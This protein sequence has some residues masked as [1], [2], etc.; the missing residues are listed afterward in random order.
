MSTE[1]NWI[2]NEKGNYV[3]REDWGAAKATV[4]R[5]SCGE[6]WGIIINSEEG[7]QYVTDYFEL[8]DDAMGRAEAFLRGVSYEYKLA[9]PKVSGISQWKQQ[10]TTVN[11]VPSY[12][13]KIGNL[14]V[15]VKRAATG[16]WFYMTYS[17]MTCSAPA[18]WYDSAEKAMQVF[19]SRH[20]LD[21][22]TQ[23]ALQN[24]FKE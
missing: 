17:G 14:S 20:S 2:K 4:Y 21:A 3:L 8:P 10:K 11:G 24:L 23:I 7:G 16:K 22:A 1:S 13:R 9:K 5:T 6:G 19:D 12:G 18:G 15:S